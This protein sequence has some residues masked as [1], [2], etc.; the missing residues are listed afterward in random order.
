[1][2][3]LYAQI[4]SFVVFPYC[5]TQNILGS[6]CNFLVL[7]LDLQRTLACLMNVKCL[8]LRYEC[9]LCLVCFC[10]SSFVLIVDRSRIYN[11]ICAHSCGY[12]PCSVK[13][14][15]PSPALRVLVFATFSPQW[16]LAAIRYINVFTYC[17]FYLVKPV[18]Y[19]LYHYLSLKNDIKSVVLL[20]LIFGF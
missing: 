12:S 16:Q 7:T 6:Y 3:C 13:V 14:T 1:M 8:I 2:L 19:R 4:Y 9:Q 18:F 10:V 17:F 20:F 11:Y 15:L 5:T